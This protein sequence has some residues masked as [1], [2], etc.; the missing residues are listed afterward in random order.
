MT[1][2]TIEIHHVEGNWFE[3]T[4]RLHNLSY[5]ELLELCALI[6]AL[7]FSTKEILVE[8]LINSS[9]RIQIEALLLA[10][11]ADKLLSEL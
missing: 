5:I 1:K 2:Y 9:E 8:T 4:T 10:K 6:T 3:P 7:K 11:A